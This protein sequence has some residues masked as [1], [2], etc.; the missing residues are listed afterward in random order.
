MSEETARNLYRPFVSY[1]I[2]GENCYFAVLLGEHVTLSP[3]KNLRALPH[4][5]LIS[6][7]IYEMNEE[8]THTSI[9]EMLLTA[10]PINGSERSFFLK[11][12]AVADIKP[13]DTAH[14]HLYVDVAGQPLE[15]FNFANVKH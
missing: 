12:C 7:A 5:S 2:Y 1:D 9:D 13:R 10:R 15:A 8:P 3:V 6:L 11:I 14:K 4:K